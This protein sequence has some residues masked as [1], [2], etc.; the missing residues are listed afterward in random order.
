MN[1]KTTRHP[2]EDT[3]ETAGI[4]YATAQLE[5]DYFTEWVRSQI[6]EAARMPPE[7][8]LPLDTVQDARV[9]AKNM[10]QQ[11]EWDTKRGLDAREIERLAGGDAKGFFE[12]FHRGVTNPSTVEWL[13]EEILDIAG[14]DPRQGVL[15]GMRE[16]RTAR[17]E[18]SGSIAYIIEA[19]Y[20]PGSGSYKRF[21]VDQSWAT[22]RDA[23]HY[24]ARWLPRDQKWRAVPLRRARGAEE[25]RRPGGARGS[26]FQVI[27]SNGPMKRLG[28]ESF[29]KAEADN[30]AADL[31]AR[32]YDV[33]IVPDAAS[34]RVR[35]YAAIDSRDRVIAGPFKHYSD[36]KDKAG[37]GGHVKF[38]PKGGA[39]P[40]AREPVKH[41]RQIERSES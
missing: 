37:P 22:K 2:R 24:A 15:P 29:T 27:G 20:P 39:R 14:K 5:S 17:V 38:I 35:D 13:A 8:V 31:R 34:H 4:E 18:A 12:G 23:E 3:A 19:E 30:M 36:A 1:P 40:A 11:L 10:L 33:R 25:A 7:E 32:G 21:P 6:I 9:I 16:A 26:L 41:R 28:R